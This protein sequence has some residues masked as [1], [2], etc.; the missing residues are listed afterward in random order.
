MFPQVYADFNDRVTET[1]L[2]FQALAALDND[3]IAIVAGVA[4]QIL[5][6][7]KPPA[8]WGRMLKGAAYLVLY[9]LVEAFIRRGF[10]A[11][12]DTIHGE[13]LCGA[14]LIELVREQWIT[15]RNRKVSPFDGSPKV[16]MGMANEIVK[17]IVEKRV[18]QMAHARLPIVGNIDADVIR[19]VCDGHGVDSTVPAAAKGGAALNTVKVKRNALSHGN[20]SFVE[21]GRT[22]V[23]ADL[24]KAK[25][26]IVIFMTSI[27]QNLEKYANNK[28]YRI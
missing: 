15:Q 27:L 22:L 10:Q 7:G 4:G 23:V 14:D 3:E 12:F 6:V 9:N 11:V 13:G 16:Y 5:P 20:E 25:D 8:D 19:S 28:E 2:Y 24:I 21:V 1:N 18:V 26:E 17:E